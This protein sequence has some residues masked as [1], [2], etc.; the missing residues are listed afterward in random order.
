MQAVILCGGRGERL[1]PLT[2]CRP[3]GLLRITGETV[4]NY[5]LQQ[6][7]KAGF[8]KVTLALGYLEGMIMSEYDSGEYEGIQI[9][10]V[11]TEELGTA[12]ALHQAFDNDDM[13]IIEANSLFNFDLKRIMSFH[14]INKAIC[15]VVT[16]QLPDLSQHACFSCD[17]NGIITSI[18]HNPSKDNL[19]AVNA[20]TGVYVLSKNAFSE[21]VFNNGNDFIK[22]IIPSMIGNDKLLLYSEKDYFTKITDAAGFIKAQ[23][24]MLMEKTGF[25]IESK[26]RENK[27]FSDTSSNFNGV[28]IIPP[29]YIGANVTIEKGSVIEPCSVIDDNAVIGSRVR[30]SGSYVGE[31]AVVSSRSELTESVVCSNALIKKSVY[32]GE[33][34]I[35]GEKAVVGESSRIEDNIKIW[36]GKEVLPNS[37]ISR[38]VIIGLGK[39]LHIDD[40]NEF[41]FGTTLNAPVDFAK[42]GMAVGT[43]FNKNDV[44]VVGYSDENSAKILSESLVTGLISTGMKVFT[45]GKFKNQQIMYGT[46]RFS[47]KAG[48]FISTDYEN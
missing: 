35:I 47:A 20:Y 30:V 13:L 41:N 31:N 28:A 22:N 34:S 26:N 1:M 38:H 44:I 18:S 14:T 40:E 39:S 37:I 21:Y 5:A 19:N 46:I 12:G 10:F 32:C 3:A 9:N 43:A 24:D 11:S 4:L 7:K 45:I 23:S 48:C 25:K 17:N 29:V 6:L 42:M 16:K 33:H 2:A 8:Q 27:I 15:T 36:A